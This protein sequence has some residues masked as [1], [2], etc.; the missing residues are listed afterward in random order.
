MKATKAM[1][2]EIT[3]SE[4]VLSEI[5]G[6]AESIKVLA[7]DMPDTLP[8]SDQ[9]RMHAIYVLADHICGCCEK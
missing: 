5:L 3:I 2:E 9:Y 4:D 1:V 8:L 7:D 6:N